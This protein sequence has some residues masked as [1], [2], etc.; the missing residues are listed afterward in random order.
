MG[1]VLQYFQ[2]TLAINTASCMVCS[3][4]LIQ[5]HLQST[6]P[7]SRQVIAPE[8]SGVLGLPA[9]KRWQLSSSGLIFPHAQP[10]SQH[11]RTRAGRGGR[12]ALGSCQLRGGFCLS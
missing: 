1:R 5:P 6:S 10:Q 7:G 2:M 4:S 8:Q 11:G 12:A 9:K 3:G